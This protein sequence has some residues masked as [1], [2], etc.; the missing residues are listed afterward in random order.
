MRV[1]VGAGGKNAI[2]KSL[3]EEYFGMLSIYI[4]LAALSSRCL[5]VAIDIPLC[6]EFALFFLCV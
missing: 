3:M 5:V 4:I 2:G 1:C 6:L